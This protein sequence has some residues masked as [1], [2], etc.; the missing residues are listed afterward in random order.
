M[1]YRCLMCSLRP[2]A[3]SPGETLLWWVLVPV[4]VLAH[5]LLPVMVLVLVVL[6]VLLLVLVVVMPLLQVLLHVHVLVL[7]LVQVVQV[8]VV[9]DRVF[10]WPR[11]SE[12]ALT[13]RRS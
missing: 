12:L 1:I 3:C 6:V 10:C 13:W 2:S 11:E 5:S 7:V 8:V 4:L 9:W